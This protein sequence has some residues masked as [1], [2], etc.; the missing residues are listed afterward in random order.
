MG[1]FRLITHFSSE[2]DKEINKHGRSLMEY[3]LL[4]E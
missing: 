2:E 3:I 4:V 1:F